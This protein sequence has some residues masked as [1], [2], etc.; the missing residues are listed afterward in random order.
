MQRLPAG[1]KGPPALAQDMVTGHRAHTAP[2]CLS[3][4]VQLLC[5]LLPETSFLRCL[6][7]PLTSSE[8]PYLFTGFCGLPLSQNERVRVAGRR[9]WSRATA[10]TIQMR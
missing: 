5:P 6:S 2:S 4:G 7:L 1:Q 3:G 8:V 10:W 9:V